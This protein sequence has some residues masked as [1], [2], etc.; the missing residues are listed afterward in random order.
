MN[1]KLLVIAVAGVMAMPLA[2]NAANKHK[3][4][5][6]VN[7]SIDRG[8]ESGAIVNGESK[9]ASK[10]GMKGSM[11]TNIAD[12]KAIYQIEVGISIG[13]TNG[14]TNERDTWAGLSSKSMGTMRIGTMDTHYKQTG[15]MTDMLFG[16]SA[17]GRG[18]T[19]TQS[20]NLHD[21]TGAGLGRGTQMIRY[22][23]PSIGGAKIIAHYQ[24]TDLENNLGLGLKYKAGNYLAFVDYIDVKT[25]DGVKKDKTAMKFGGKAKFGAGSLAIQYELDDG[26]IVKTKAGPAKGKGDQLHVQGA[27]KIGATTL[28]LTVGRND[29]NVGWAVVAQQK[30]AKKAKI[31]I[32]YAA[33]GSDYDSDGNKDTS[34]ITF[35]MKTAF[36]K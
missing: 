18:F 21:G 32:G 25:Q 6:A 22:D 3:T 10:I 26:D 31:Y 34:V 35:G 17:A 33:S 2:A 28:I 19:G 36:G 13:E 14:L 4:Y 27:Y 1:K 16:T 5:G 9:K 20:K 15:K 11:K 12:F 23:S 29:E 30:V 24:L 8:N 7:I